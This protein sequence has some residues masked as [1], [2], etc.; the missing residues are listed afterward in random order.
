M[1]FLNANPDARHPMALSAPFAETRA[2]ESASHD[3]EPTPPP[4]ALQF[5]MLRASVGERREIAQQVAWIEHMMADRSRD[6][7]RGSPADAD[8]QMLP[9]AKSALARV[10]RVRFAHLSEGGKAGDIARDLVTWCKAA[11][12]QSVPAWLWFAIPGERMPDPIAY[13]QLPLREWPAPVLAMVLSLS[14]L[15]GANLSDLSIP[16]GDLRGVVAD[17]ARFAGANCNGACW[18]GASLRA[19]E[20][21]H[22]HQVD[23]DFESADLRGTRFRAADLSR[24]RLVRADLRGSTFQYTVMRGANVG[25]AKCQGVV[26]SR[27][28]LEAALFQRAHLDGACFDDGTARRM[29]LTAA[30]A[31]R[32]RWTAMTMPQCNALGADL[33]GAEFRDCDL[34]EWDASGAK[35]NGAS[36]VSCDLRGARFCGAS[37]KDVRLGA[38]C[39]LGGTQWRNA[40]LRLDAKWLRSL[41][42]TQLAGVVRSWETFPV[43]AP[44][45]RA[46]VFLQLLRALSGDS[47][48]MMAST[49]NAPVLQRLPAHVRSSEWLGRILTTGGEVGGIGDHDAFAELRRQWMTRMLDRLT[50]AKLTPSQAES[51]TLALVTVLETRCLDASPAD[52]RAL[53]GPICQVLFWAGE[54]AGGASAMWAQRLRAAWFKALPTALHTAL[55]ADGVDAFDPSFVLLTNG[56]VALRLPIRCLA[57]ALDPERAST[58]P[59]A[60]PDWRWLGARVVVRDAASDD[61]LP[62]TTSQL[63]ALLREF[64]CLADLWP[65]ERSLDAFV[66]LLGR[67]VGAVEASDADAVLRSRA[68]CVVPVLPD[69]MGGVPPARPLG[70]T[71]RFDATV[72]AGRPPT[73]LLLRRDAHLD[74]NEVLSQS[75]RITDGDGVFPDTRMSRR[76]WLTAIAAGFVWLATQCHRP[77]IVRDS[78]AA[79]ML[80]PASQALYLSYARAA[81]DESMVG[82]TASQRIA[83]VEVLRE[84]LVD[85]SSEA[86]GRHFLEWLMC[87]GI[88]ALPGLEQ[89]CRQTL[90]WDW[91][92]RLPLHPET[93]QNVMNTR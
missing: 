25:E 3:H 40:R 34:T 78:S 84:S 62:G 77:G 59:M 85:A 92:M 86:L 87:P 88:R 68:G 9:L 6:E 42:P 5:A 26:F 46:D 28:R 80:A 7:R 44:A 66:R 63:Q 90:P 17:G 50:D 67:W 27:V 72:C 14:R 15:R 60:A 33:R 43:D 18:S 39:N 38:D 64:G 58:T 81:L 73:R 91:A 55:S 22:S 31:K 30:H 12:R 56:D 13:R 35:L 41:P 51:F 53:A 82:A 70:T 65:T 23:A 83:E 71:D 4:G 8:A 19:A 10:W 36:W 21:D 93:L 20:F 79:P 54:G 49:A 37:L 47:V 52:V 89:A 69:G 48:G 61:F 16:G 11:R 57:L 74:I 32:S 75:L 2:G 1:R 24:A 29:Q 45:L 76:V